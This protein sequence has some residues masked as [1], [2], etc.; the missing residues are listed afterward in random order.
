MSYARFYALRTRTLWPC[1]NADVMP[2]IHQQDRLLWS[3]NQRMR[4]HMRFFTDSPERFMRRGI[5]VVRCNLAE[6]SLMH[7]SLADASIARVF[8]HRK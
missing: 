5:N 3:C 2:P 4:I 1:C 8:S 7:V 6:R